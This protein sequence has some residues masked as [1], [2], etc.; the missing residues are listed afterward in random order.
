MHKIHTHIHTYI[1]TCIP[2]TFTSV[3]FCTYCTLLHC[4]VSKYFLEWILKILHCIISVKSD[5]HS[6][7]TPKWHFFEKLPVVSYHTAKF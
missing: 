5:P 4:I 2:G 7:F 6:S 3:T 1:H